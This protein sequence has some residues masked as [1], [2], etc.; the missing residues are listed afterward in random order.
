MREYETLLHGL[1]PKLANDDRKRVIEKVSLA[2]AG[3]LT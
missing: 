3:E 2:M 1:L